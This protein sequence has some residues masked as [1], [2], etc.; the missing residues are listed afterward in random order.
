MMEGKTIHQIIDELLV[1][2]PGETELHYMHT[3]GLHD[4]VRGCI[5]ALKTAI[6]ADAVPVSGNSRTYNPETQV[7]ISRETAEQMAEYLAGEC[8]EKNVQLDWGYR[9]RDELR[10]ALEVKP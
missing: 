4:G 9:V 6:A 3:I 5:A 7:V 1:V 10:A 2:V 8:F